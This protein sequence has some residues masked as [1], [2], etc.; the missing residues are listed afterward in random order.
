MLRLP[1][2]IRWRSGYVVEMIVRRGGSSYNQRKLGEEGE[3]IGMRVIIHCKGKLL[4]GFKE[5]SE[6]CLPRKSARRR[7]LDVSNSARVLEL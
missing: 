3:R 7:N 2:K 4:I 5:T 1:R 6:N